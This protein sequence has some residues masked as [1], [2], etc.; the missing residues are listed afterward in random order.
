MKHPMKWWERPL[1]CIFGLHVFRNHPS[2]GEWIY[3]QRCWGERD[4]S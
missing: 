1:L 4:D 3:C 2:R